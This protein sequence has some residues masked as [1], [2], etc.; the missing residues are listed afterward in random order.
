M[1]VLVLQN[2]TKSG[3]AYLR[4]PAEKYNAFLDICMPHLKPDHNLPDSDKD[5]DGFILLGGA[6]N[7]DEGSEHPWLEKAANLVGQFTD[8]GKPVLGICLG[9]QIIARAFGAKT[10]NMPK[11]EIGF[12]EIQV[13][14]KAQKD[15]LL[16]QNFGSS[17]FLAE[18]HKQTFEIPDGST[19]LMKG[20][21]C[22]NQAFKIGESTYAFQPHFEITPDL[23]RHWVD[24]SEELI[25]SYAP[26]LPKRLSRLINL[27][28]FRSHHFCWRVGSAWFNKLVQ[29]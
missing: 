16:G 6:M 2:H 14:E 7:A 17:I 26:E 9:S 13:T 28:H 5:Y 20:Q 1:R 24:N 21:T 4:E 22:Q 29:Q 27:H 15:E 10:Y 8:K 18:F 11:A 25:A 12:F 23:F 3:L 19:L